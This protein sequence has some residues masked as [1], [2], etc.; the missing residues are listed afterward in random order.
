VYEGFFEQAED[1]LFIEGEQLHPDLIY[2]VEC[3]TGKLEKKVRS[4]GRQ[5]IQRLFFLFVQF[6]A[7]IVK[8]VEVYPAAHSLHVPEK[9]L[10]F[11]HFP[12]GD[13]YAL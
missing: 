2:V 7:F 11:D 12:S 1:A 9:L 5:K 8:G 4:I 6:N 3:S 10:V 13:L